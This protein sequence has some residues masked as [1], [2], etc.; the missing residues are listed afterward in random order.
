MKTRIHTGL[1]PA[2]RVLTNGAKVLVSQSRT[3]PV[4]TISAAC[5]AGSLYDPDD[6]PG[7][8]Y[9]LSRVID[10]GS[11]QRS[12]AEIAE[13]LDLRGVSLRVHVTR[14]AL[15]L[16]CDC[17]AEDFEDVLSILAD[18]IRQPTCPETE[19]GIRRGEILTAIRQDDDNPAVT[20]LDR[21]MALLYGE[22]HPYG[23]RPK[24]TSVSVEQVSRPALRALHR[25]RVVPGE[26]S[27]VVVGDVDQDTAMAL[28][29]AAFDDWQ[30]TSHPGTALES[31]SGA[32]TRRRV[33]VPMM[34][35]AQA[36]IGYGFITIPRDDPAY[37]AYWLMA[38]ILGQ[39]GMGGRLG[40]SLRE[41]QGMAYYA[42]CGFEASVIAGPL[43]L[44]AGVN[45]ANVDRAVA[46]IDDEVSKMG[47]AGVT[48]D[49]LANSKRYLV[50]SLPRTLETNAGI[51]AFLQNVQQFDLGL[52]YDRRLPGLLN[53]VTRDEVNDAARL[54]LVP[55]HA[56]LVIAGPYEES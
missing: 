30:A 42:F 43:I 54:T 50:G 39:Y 5:H 13:E 35:K 11:A 48:E 14:H 29:A 37:H 3:T 12:A 32:T 17:L 9:F 45:A 28:V 15:M 36:D 22:T 16:S 19:I 26:L 47:A 55:D 49:E 51:A 23:R 41:R 53:Q 4:V 46:S 56:A 44:R 8:A 7:L 38:N 21:L 27:L 6:Q 25:D 20:A 24:G 31:P 33:V 10:R 34:N 2:E 40:H 1:V 52:D 18:I